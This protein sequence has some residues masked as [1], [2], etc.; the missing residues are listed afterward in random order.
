MNKKGQTL[1]IALLSSIIYFIVGMMIIN[2]FMP[3]ITTARTD[4]SCSTPADITDGTKF[5][6]LILDIQV[7]YFITMIFSVVL[8]AITDR[9]LL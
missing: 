7:I 9:V 5:T 2:F 4:L 3:E 8:G 1:A 6:C